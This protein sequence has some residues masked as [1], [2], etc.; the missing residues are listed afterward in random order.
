M[1][2]RLVSWWCALWVTWEEFF[3]MFI[4]WIFAPTIMGDLDDY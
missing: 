4:H 1:L 2:G 3:S